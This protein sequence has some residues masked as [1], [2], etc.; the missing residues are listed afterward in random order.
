M[1]QVERFNTH[2][3]TSVNTHTLRLREAFTLKKD[4][5]FH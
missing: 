5:G 4:K 3:T 1:F 2:N